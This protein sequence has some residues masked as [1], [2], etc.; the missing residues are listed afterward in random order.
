M[1]SDHPHKEYSYNHAVSL[2]LLPLGTDQQP[3]EKNSLCIRNLSP[4]NRTLLT[5]IVSGM[6][7]AGHISHKGCPQEH[8]YVFYSAEDRDTVLASLNPHPTNSNRT[9]YGLGR[10][11]DRPYS[12]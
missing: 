12:L 7:L 11:E 10:V 3:D 5:T 9:W 4:V 2:G 8:C 1:T 6:A